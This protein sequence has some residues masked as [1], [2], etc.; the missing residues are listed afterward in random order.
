VF[1]DEIGRPIPL[2]IPNK[3]L[4]RARGAAG[5]PTGSLPVL[6]DMRAEIV[7]HRDPA[8]APVWSIEGS[9]LG[10]AG[11]CALA[12]LGEVTPGVGA[13]PAPFVVT[14]CC[15]TSTIPRR[16]CRGRRDRQMV[17]WK[18]RGSG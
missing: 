15:S 14:V 11:R 18:Q 16:L 13:L 8:S 2:N 5:I 12:W 6:R 17:A 4:V 7:A 3:P 10:W 9:R 1:C